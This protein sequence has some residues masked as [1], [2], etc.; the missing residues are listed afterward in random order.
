MRHEGGEAEEEQEEVPSSLDRIE[1]SKKIVDPGT[2]W[3]DESPLS[4]VTIQLCMI[5]II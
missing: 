3:F 4:I 2:F 1:T 5:Y